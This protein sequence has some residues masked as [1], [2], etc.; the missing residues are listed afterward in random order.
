LTATPARGARHGLLVLAIGMLGLLV[1]LPASAS[2]VPPTADFTWSPQLPLAG[3]QVSFMSHSS[4]PDGPIEVWS[5]D[6]NGNGTF[7]GTR[8]TLTTTFN[9]PGTHSVG[10]QVTQA[11]EVA[12]VYKDVFVLIP[13]SFNHFPENP[14]PGEQVLF[15]VPAPPPSVTYSWDFDGD[16]T[17][18]SPAGT[19]TFAYHAF[20]STGAHAV[21]VRVDRTLGGAE[22]SYG[23]AAQ[24]IFVSAAAGLTARGLR[25]L[26][27][28]PVVRI[29]GKVTRR[30]TRIRRLTVSAP[31][32]AKIRIKCNG[33]GC[34]FKRATRTARFGAGRPLGQSSAVMRMRRLEGRLLRPRTAL[35]VFVTKDPAI[36]K[37]T[38]FT[39]RKRKPPVRLDKCLAPG[40]PAP[41]PCPAG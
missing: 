23:T 25:L 34:P 9:Q 7:H 24:T 30:G 36:G 2:A 13:V 32:G 6:E 17:Y 29:A 22:D 4:D 37:Y 26:A 38:K 12:T 39:V 41:V 20:P 1:L 28:F 33:R 10:L 19:A 14:V 35:K 27:P 3:Q 18:E 21:G 8:P 11:T 31:A 15:F 40:A 5:W 16:G